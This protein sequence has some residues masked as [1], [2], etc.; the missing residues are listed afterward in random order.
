MCSGRSIRTWLRAAYIAPCNARP[1]RLVPRVGIRTW[2]RVRSRPTL[3][4]IG[5]QH[6]RVCLQ[7]EPPFGAKLVGVRKPR[8]HN[9]TCSLERACIRNHRTAPVHGSPAAREVAV[10]STR[11][12]LPTQA[13]LCTLHQRELDRL[14]T[15]RSGGALHLYLFIIYLFFAAL[16]CIVLPGGQCG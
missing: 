14:R 5:L 12:Y 7:V 13:R 4:T 15:V 16:H 8:T 2:L 6:A 10:A 1:W 3:P 11:L 9:Q